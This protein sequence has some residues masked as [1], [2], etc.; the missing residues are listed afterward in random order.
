M[1]L[2][3]A[4][5]ACAQARVCGVPSRET[6]AKQRRSPRWGHA[7]RFFA[8]T[9]KR[10]VGQTHT[11]GDTAY[12]AAKRAQAARRDQPCDSARSRRMPAGVAPSRPCAAVRGSGGAMPLALHLCERTEPAGVS[13][14][15]E[16][17][18][19][20]ASAHLQSAREGSKMPSSMGT[21]AAIVAGASSDLD[22][23]LAVHA[24]VAR[25]RRR[26]RSV[27]A[28]C[29]RSPGDGDRKIERHR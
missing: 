21:L 17:G 13:T 7:W 8:N 1:I 11:H 24:P 22:G 23:S 4:R 20:D 29:E 3:P 18:R 16:W 15:D 5:T 12:M 27:L 9:Q 14:A 2:G 10:P 25:A 26:P 6:N 19:E 28:T